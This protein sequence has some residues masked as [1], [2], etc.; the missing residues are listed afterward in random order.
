MA[1]MR[2]AVW[3]VS[4]ARLA[5]IKIKRRSLWLSHDYALLR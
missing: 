2:P 5:V 4:V 3:L 1:S